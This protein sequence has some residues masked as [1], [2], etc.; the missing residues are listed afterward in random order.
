MSKFK[1][2]QH[3]CPYD[4]TALMPETK[5]KIEI[6]N[7]KLKKP[8]VFHKLNM[9]DRCL[10]SLLLQSST[11]SML[12]RILPHLRLEQIFQV[13]DITETSVANHLVIVD[14]R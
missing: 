9:N 8:P 14:T 2:I 10:I 4:K 5:G 6:I 1:L 3:K 13:L 11:K 7:N 12:T